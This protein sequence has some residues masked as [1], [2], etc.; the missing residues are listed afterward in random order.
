VQPAL[1]VFHKLQQKIL[2]MAAVGDVP[3]MTGQK[4]SIGTWHW[5]LSLKWWFY[6]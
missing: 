3:D 1:A 4:M 6:P 5:L 2:L